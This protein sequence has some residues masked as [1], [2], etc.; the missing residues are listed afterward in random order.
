[1]TSKDRR[2]GPRDLRLK[3]QRKSINQGRGPMSGATGDLREK[4][5]GILYSR[6][7]ESKPPPVRPKPAPEASKPPRKSVVAKAPAPKIKPA[8]VPKK[9]S[10]PKVKKPTTILPSFFPPPWGGEGLHT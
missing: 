6:T 5:S 3:L 7:V 4:L 2:V 10:Q 9:A 1:M 8:D